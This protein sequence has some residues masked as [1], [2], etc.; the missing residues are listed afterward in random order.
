M[1]WSVGV[2]KT[3]HLNEASI[4]L[5]LRLPNNMFEVRKASLKS[6]NGVNILDL[7]VAIMVSLSP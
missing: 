3:P 5:P 7:Q 2:D 6:G 4:E 1:I